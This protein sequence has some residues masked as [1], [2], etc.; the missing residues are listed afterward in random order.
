MLIMRGANPA[1]NVLHVIFGPE[2]ELFTDVHGAKVCDISSIL[3]KMDSNQPVFLSLTRCKSEAFTAATLKGTGA[4]F[5]NSFSG[6]AVCA[7]PKDPVLA[8]KETHG[9][10]VPSPKDQTATGY[11]QDGPV[12][13]IN[14]EMPRGRC[15]YCGSPDVPLVP[16]QNMAICLGCTQIELGRL[17]TREA[18]DLDEMAG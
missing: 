1:G 17:Q 14:V 7:E 12:S 13:S 16:I 10:A 8:G 18:Q 4:D 5:V 3:V 2:T 6:A 11:V 15:T 9:C